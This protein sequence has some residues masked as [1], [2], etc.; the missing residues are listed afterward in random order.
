MAEEGFDAHYL[1]NVSSDCCKTWYPARTDCPDL[2]TA[3]NPE[4]EDEPWHSM[5]YSMRNY[6]FPDFSRNSCGHGRD[7]P[8]WMGF[9]N[10][11]KHYL[12]RTGQECCEKFFPKVSGCPYEVETQTD[13]YWTSYQDNIHNLDDMPVKYNHTYYP[14]INAGTCVNGTDYPPWMA[15]DVDFKRLYLFK[16]LEGCCEM[17]FTAFDLEGCVNNVIQGV[18]EVEPCSTNRPECNHTSST[19][20]GVAKLEMWYPDMDGLKCKNDGHMEK[21][22]LADGYSIWYLFNTH[23]QCCSAFGFC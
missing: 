3:V 8:A 12:F 11:E 14:D 23:Q 21:W 5:P 19:D 16:N 20:P 2:Q 22:M 15:S 18:Y 6:F 10:Y 7:Y 4:A 17:W 13:Y 1:Y 9:N